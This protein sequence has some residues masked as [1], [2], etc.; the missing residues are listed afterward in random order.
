MPLPLGEVPNVVRRRGFRPIGLFPQADL[1]TEKRNR[2]F[3][4]IVSASAISCSA[5]MGAVK[6]SSMVQ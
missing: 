3:H 2:I 4:C 5:V 6:R 1:S